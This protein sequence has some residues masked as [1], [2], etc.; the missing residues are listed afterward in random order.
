MKFSITQLSSAY[1]AHP[2]ILLKQGRTDVE[3]IWHQLP[4]YRRQSGDMKKFLTEDPQMLGGNVKNLVA[5]NLCT[6]VSRLSSL[7]KNT[8]ISK[9][10]LTCS[11]GV[12]S[13][14]TYYLSVIQLNSPLFSFV[15]HK[16][17]FTPF[18]AQLHR[19]YQRSVEIKVT[20][21]TQRNYTELISLG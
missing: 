7:S 6:A 9:L 21:E 4:N 15:H 18:G 20:S 3:K 13:L 16:F 17:H 8:A 10:L 2:N 12:C 14:G 5:W 1:L 11:A 19:A